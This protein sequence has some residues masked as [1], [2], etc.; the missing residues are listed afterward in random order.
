M[1][2]ARNTGC[3]PAV[4]LGIWSL[5]ETQI[6]CPHLYLGPLSRPAGNNLTNKGTAVP[7]WTCTP[8]SAWQCHII[9]DMYWRIS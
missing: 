5:A 7:F 4:Q 2:G 6:Q 9:D 8:V 3:K 1:I